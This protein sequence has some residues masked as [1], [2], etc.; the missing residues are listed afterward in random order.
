[1]TINVEGADAI[2]C[3]LLRM[4]TETACRPL[5]KM[6]VKMAV[7]LV[8]T[9]TEECNAHHRS[10]TITH[11]RRDLMV[12]I[13]ITVVR[14]CLE[15][16]MVGGGHRHHT[17]MVVGALQRTAIIMIDRDLLPVAAVVI[18]AM[19]KMII[20]GDRDHDDVGATGDVVDTAVVLGLVP[21]HVVHPSLNQS[22]SRSLPGL[23]RRVALRT[24]ITRKAPML[25]QKI[26]GRC[27]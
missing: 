12:K 9:F 2:D 10:H 15:G 26:R 1:M 11:P 25:I 24:A 8:R 18:R 16:E 20:P 23:R 19:T 21:S 5:E 4:M 14:R 17:G 6:A 22:Q 13:R 27:L 3:L 7:N